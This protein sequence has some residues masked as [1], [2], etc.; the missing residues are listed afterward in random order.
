MAIRK[1]TAREKTRMG[2]LCGELRQ[3]WIYENRAEIKA[4][5]RTLLQSGLAVLVF[6]V[7]EFRGAC[8]YDFT[9]P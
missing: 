5:P 9:L 4:R 6:T 1:C 8:G 7:F 3:V 2:E